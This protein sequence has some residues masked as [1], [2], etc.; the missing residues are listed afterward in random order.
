MQA[1]ET[2]YL[3]PTNHKG[4]RIVAKCDAGRVVVSYDHALGIYGNH[5]A[6]AK[7]LLRKLEW[8]GRWVGGGVAGGFVFVCA[9]S[10]DTFSAEGT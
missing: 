10:Q 8:T 9:L 3:G 2:K 6:A 4:A 7:A 1:I 5:E